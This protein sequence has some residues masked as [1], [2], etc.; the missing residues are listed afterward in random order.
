MQTTEQPRP[1]QPVVWHV[2]EAMG[3]G[4]ATAIHHFVRSAPGYDHVLLCCLRSQHQ[5]GEADPFTARRPSRRS[6]PLGMAELLLS[7]DEHLPPP[8]VVHVHSAWAGLIARLVLFRHRARIVYSP[9]AY[10]FERTDISTAARTAAWWLERL[11]AP[12]TRVVVAV[13]PHEAQLAEGLG[14]A[15]R[16]VPNVAAFPD[17]E[18]SLLSGGS[19]TAAHSEDPVA[20]LVTVGRVEPQKD[21]EFFTATVRA[22]RRRGVEV[23]ALWIGAGPAELEDELRAGGVQVTGWVDRAQVLDAVRSA[24][25]YVH[26]AAWEGNPL[27]VLE[28][29]ALGRPLAVRSIPAMVSL[30]HPETNSTPEELADTIVTLLAGVPGVPLRDP[31]RP[32]TALEGIY[33]ELVPRPRARRVGRTARLVQTALGLLGP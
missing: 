29:E 7:L 25:V 3:G 20:R 9:H 24:S 21:P 31:D 15:V 32:P 19:S 16:F 33:D 10:Y 26:T 30:G 22:V 17:H 11:L 4:L 6:G 18:Q 5:T 28:A 14:C 1:A 13:S 12:L 27:T 8:D 23:D 2:T